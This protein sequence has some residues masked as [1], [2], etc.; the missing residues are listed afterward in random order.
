MKMNKIKKTLS[1]LLSAAIISNMAITV[2]ATPSS[3]N[4]KSISIPVICQPCN[5]L[6]AEIR[7]TD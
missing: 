1:L 5:N 6:P 3:E 4:T 7:I 2:N